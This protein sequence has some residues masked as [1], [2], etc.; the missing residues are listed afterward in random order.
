MWENGKFIEREQDDGLGHATVEWVVETEVLFTFT[1][2]VDSNSAQDKA[3]FKVKANEAKDAF[4]AKK[5]EEDNLG[6]AI[7]NY[8][9]A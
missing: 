7:T 6:T 8:M 9:N 1:R 4:L 3:L 5:T 2:Y